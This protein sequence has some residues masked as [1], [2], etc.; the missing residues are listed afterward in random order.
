MNDN[1]LNGKLN[2]IHESPMPGKVALFWDESFLW[3]LIAYD[4]FL[5]LSVNFDVITSADIR[6]GALKGYDLVFV[7]GGWA[8]NKIKALGE[9]GKRNIQRF[10]ESGGSYLGFC[11]GAGLALTHKHGLGLV[12]VSRKATKERVPSFSGKIKLTHERSEHPVWKGI[13]DRTA[14][15]AWWPGQFSIDAGSPVSILAS[16]N[17][18]EPGAYVADLLIEQ[19]MDWDSLEHSYGTNLNPERIKGE[20]AVIEA[21]YGKG[22]VILSYLHFETPGDAPGHKVLLNILEYLAGRSIVLDDAGESR[23]TAPDRYGNGDRGAHAKAIEIS[24]ELQAAAAD[25]MKYGGSKS[26]W[27]WRAPWII[28]WRRGVRGIEYCTLYTMLKWLS[29]IIVAVEVDSNIVDNLEDLKEFS[30]SFFDK[31]KELLALEHDAIG[32]GPISPL[33]IDDERIGYIRE[34]LFSSSKSFGGYFKQ[35]IDKIDKILLPLLIYTKEDKITV[36]T[37][38]RT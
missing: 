36:Q 22:I 4:T 13:K 7:P 5:K 20:P 9:I 18:P 24:K 38:N 8:S 3:G 32:N 10:I 33:K 15:H 1:L 12:P 29:E 31:A 11:G 28:Q 25:L 6:N 35:I 2:Q 16:Y 21:R 34:E 17:T 30:L 26:L 19:T 14:F 27:F 23:S 37:H